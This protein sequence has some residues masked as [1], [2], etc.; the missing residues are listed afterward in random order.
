MIPAV[1]L[2]L[3]AQLTRNYTGFALESTSDQVCVFAVALFLVALQPGQT[4]AMGA[5]I[6]SLGNALL[7]GSG[8]RG[9]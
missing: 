1:F 9:V 2:S 7:Y 3:R 4:R 5:E 6:I 8:E